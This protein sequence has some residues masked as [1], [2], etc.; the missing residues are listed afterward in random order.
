MNKAKIL[1]HDVKEFMGRREQFK[2]RMWEILGAKDG[3][4]HQLNL[5]VHDLVLREELF[6]IDV[7][8]KAM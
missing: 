8:L 3:G 4:G 7:E 1:E 5:L 6:A 2:K